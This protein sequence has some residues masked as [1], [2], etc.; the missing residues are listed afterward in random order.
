MIGY[1]DIGGAGLDLRVAGTTAITVVI[2]FGGR[3]LIVDDHDGRKALGGFVVGLPVEAM[4]IH[5]ELAE[6]VEIRLP[7][8][9]A[10]SLLGISP[11]DLGRGA[12]GLEDLGGARARR[13]RE[14]LAAARTWDERF[15]L[16]TSFLAQ[17]DTTARTPSPEVL[18]AWQRILGSRGQVRIG[19]L[20][21]SLGWS[22]K[23]LSVRFESQIGLAPKRAAMLVRFRHAVDGL[24][25]GHPAADVATSCG[26]ADQAHLCRDM[27]IFTDHTPRALA[28]H[29]R[30]AIARDRYRAWGKFVQYGTGPL[31]R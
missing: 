15:T 3:D 31:D 7:P 27:S 5:S 20:A 18:T 28:A 4:R 16:A 9:R 2:E 13:L 29:Y 6:C 11:A 14:Q 23:R 30:P 25:A 21:Q 19:E 8:A 1:R 17:G 10:Y 24:L 22:N 26:Y 12:L